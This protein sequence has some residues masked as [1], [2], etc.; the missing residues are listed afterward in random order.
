MRKIEILD[1]TLRD[2]GYINNWNFGFDNIK[3]I[4]NNLA[5]A[6][7]RYIECG[8]IN[9][10]NTFNKNQSIFTD[11]NSI[12]PLIHTHTNSRFTSMMIINKYDIKKLPKCSNTFTNIIRLAFHKKDRNKIIDYA[13]I[14]KKKGYKLFLQPTIIM[15][16]SNEEI[17]DLLNLCK[18]TLKPDG[19]AIVDTL[20]EM[21]MFDIKRITKLFDNYLDIE[22]KI[23]FHGHNNLQLAFSNAITFIENVKQE[24]NIII[25]TTLMGMGR[26]TGNVCTEL[27]TDYLN[28][29]YNA[30]YDYYK[31]LSII[32]NG[33]SIYKE[34]FDWGYNTAYM[35][36][37]KNKVHP[38]YA[39][40]FRNKIKK[41]SLIDLNYLIDKIPYQDKNEFNEYVAKC[42]L[43]E[44]N[45]EKSCISVL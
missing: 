12:K 16:Y 23:L 26:D 21:N 32:D 34:K 31:I 5:L 38:N 44:F 20:G 8:F 35:L 45:T 27:L 40:F 1:C 13:T 2:G 37:A 30:D 3:Y 10:I 17:I 7:I 29:Y 41:I 19:I 28:Q 15:S 14:I 9:N 43:E 39:K 4:I 42:I 11:P 33:I 18:T 24:R 36:N 6:N 22:T 25:D